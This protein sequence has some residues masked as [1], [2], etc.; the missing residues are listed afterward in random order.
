MAFE[1]V[2]VRAVIEGMREFDRDSE[3][4]N[5]KVGLMGRATKTLSGPLSLAGK[6]FGG[7]GSSILRMGEIAG[8]FLI[9]NTLGRIAD[10]FSRAT[11]AAV[12]FGKESVMAAA[13]VE[14]LDVVLDL[15]G[16]RAGFTDDELD[17]MVDGIKDLGIETKVAQKLLIQFNRYSLDMADATK[18]A[19]VAQ[20]AA[21]ISMQDSSQAL[22]GLMHGITT[23]NTRVLRTYGINIGSV[24]DAQDAY[25]ASIGKTRD[26][27]SEAEKMQATLDKI[28][29]EGTKIQGA[30]EAAMG[31]AGKQARSMKRHVDELKN[32]LGKPF[33]GAF[34][35]II[36]SATDLLKYFRQITEEGTT[37]NKA[38]KRVAE[39]IET[40]AVIA[41]DKLGG[42]LATAVFH[43]G[44]FFDLLESGALKPLIDRFKIIGGI[45]MRLVLGPFGS[46]LTIMGK[47]GK[48]VYELATGD[49]SFEDMIPEWMIAAW[50]RFQGILDRFGAW[51]D[52]HGP[53]ITE[54]I[55]EIGEGFRTFIEDQAGRVADFVDDELMKFSDWFD[56]HGEDIETAVQRIADYFNDTLV[57]AVTDAWEVWIRPALEAF[58]GLVR[59]LG[60]VILEV[61]NGDY[62]TA[63]ET[64]KEIVE[65]LLT[66]TL[67]GLFE[68]F[69]DWILRWLLGTTWDEVWEQW[70]KNLDMF[71]I[72]F[73]SIFGPIRDFFGTNLEDWEGRGSEG[74]GMRGQ[75]PTGNIPGT[76]TIPGYTG[77]G[78][79]NSYET[80]L[81]I[82]TT[83]P[84]EP[85]IQDLKM[86]E[87]LAGWR[88]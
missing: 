57:P 82:N 51:W 58:M 24:I 64:A 54:S 88:R 53:G 72:I 13:R 66:K 75:A 84:S 80:N 83:A 23:M 59:D 70:R 69:T 42:F 7:V 52:K 5:R 14:E 43:F 8:G 28:L 50:G 38:L 31:T 25:A 39:F 19:R 74:G 46:F 37:L 47:I 49:R 65:E 3:R 61:I 4:F 20:D 60:V 22:D 16:N 34:S 11:Q 32:S 41:F 55:G 44:N 79:S 35:K 48:L 86:I 81:T 63:W 2:G 62:A 67:P 6:A 77:R 27:L 85:I 21:V 76:A 12:S 45:V 1:R 17:G 87:D 40:G 68:D 78:G 29:V 73:D 9:A 10:G 30:Y 33:L 56:E 36:E 18:L 71:R 15:I 26:E